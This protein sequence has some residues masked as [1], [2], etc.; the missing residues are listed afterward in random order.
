MMLIYIIRFAPSSKR[1][2]SG[3]IALELAVLHGFANGNGKNASLNVFSHII[4]DFVTE[5]T[6]QCNFSICFIVTEFMGGLRSVF[7]IWFS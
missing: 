6:E 1:Q 3:V 5:C 4:V 7:D 2:D